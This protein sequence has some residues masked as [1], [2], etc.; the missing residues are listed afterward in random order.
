MN[1]PF[2]HYVEELYY[3]LS[4]ALIAFIGL[5]LIKPGFVIAYINL[6][7]WLIFW[8]ISATLL[9]YIRK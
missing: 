5:E 7:Y 9:L 1:N 3:F 6:N 8:L 2:R 4:A